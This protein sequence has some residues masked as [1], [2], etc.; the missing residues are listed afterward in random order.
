[1]PYE[2]EIGTEVVAKSKYIDVT[3]VG[4][5][6]SIIERNGIIYYAVCSNLFLAEEIKNENT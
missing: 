3:C 1:M 6:H 2:Y 4:K 5:I